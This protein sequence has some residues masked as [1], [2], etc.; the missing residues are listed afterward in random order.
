[1]ER[2]TGTVA[3]LG[4]VDA[5]G[6][7]EWIIAIPFEEWPQQNRLA[8]GLLRPAMVNDLSWHRFGEIAGPV[9]SGLMPQ[10]QG[11]NAINW[12]LTVN[13]PGA[14]IDPHVDQQ[15]EHWVARVH[16][17]LT[18]TPESRFEVGGEHHHMDLGMAYLVNTTVLHSVQNDGSVPRVHFM[19]DVVRA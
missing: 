8:D 14:G 9:V 4:P 19:F 11:C 5:T 3:P 17:P 1:M 13:M 2:F 10:F 16:V 7:T 6:M 12:L 15:P 18:T